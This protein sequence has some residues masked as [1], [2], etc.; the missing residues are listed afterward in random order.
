MATVRDVLARKG[1]SV[2]SITAERS[3]L[4]AARLMNE[5]GIG[6]L[7]VVE[8]GEL[9]GVFTERDVLRRVVAERRDPEQTT[10][11]E[12]MTSNVITC[13]AGTSLEECRAVMTGKRV[14]HLPVIG[15]AG[16]VG[17]VTIGD[18]L[19]LEVAEGRDTISQLQHYVFDTRP[20]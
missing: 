15:E 2:V 19:A 12:V 16:L 4:E 10:V 8:D 5:Q 7:V 3:V 17:I 6:G 11:S 14:R 9:V 13:S 20:V 1:N 18:L